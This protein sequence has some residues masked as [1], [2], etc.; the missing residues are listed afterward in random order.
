MVLVGVHEELGVGVVE[1][2]AGGRR[3]GAPSATALLTLRQMRC[4]AH[5][6]A[7]PSRS[8]VDLR[9]VVV[10]PLDRH[11]VHR[12]AHRAGDRDRLGVPRVARPRGSGAG[13]RAHTSRAATFAPHWVSTTPGVIVACSRRLY[14][15]PERLADPA[16]G[17][18]QLRARRDRAIR[19]RARA[20]A[21]RRAGRARAG[22]AGWR[23]RGRRSRRSGAVAARRP[24][25]TAAPLPGV[26]AAGCSRI[27]CP[28]SRRSGP[29]PARTVP[30]VLPS[31]TKIT[32]L[33]GGWSATNST[34][35]LP[36]SAKRS[37]S[38]KSG[39]TTE[40][41]A[42]TTNHGTRSS[43]ESTGAPWLVRGQRCARR[44][45]GRSGARAG[46]AAASGSEPRTEAYLLRKSRLL[47]FVALGA[48]LLPIVVATRPGAA[49]RT[50]SRSA[51]TRSS[52]SGPGTS[53]PR[54]R[55]CSGRGRPRRRA[56]GRTSTT[57]A[58]C[59]STCSRSRSGSSARSTG[60]PIGTAPAEHRRRSSASRSIAYRRGGAV[61]GSAAMLV[62]AVMCWAMGSELLFDPWQPHSLLLPFLFF[63][64]A[65]WALSCGDLVML[66]WAVGVGSLVVA[67]APQLR[68][69]RARARAVGRRRLLPDQPA[70]GRARAVR[71]GAGRAAGELVARRWRSPRSSLVLCWAQPVWEEFTGPGDGNIT[72]LVES[73]STSNARSRSAS[74]AARG[75]VATVLALPPWWLRPSFNDAFVAADGGPHARARA[76]SASP[77]L[78]SLALA[79]GGLLVDRGDLRGVRPRRASAPRYRGAARGRH[80]GDRDHRRPLHRRRTFPR[81]VL[82][83][84]AAPV[85]LAVA[86]RRVHDVRRRSPPTVG[87]GRSQLSSGRR[88][89][90]LVASFVGVT[91]L[92]A[93]L[94]L[95]TYR[96]A[97][98]PD[99]GLVRHPGR[100]RPRPAARRAQRLR[101]R[102][103][104]TS[105]ACSSPSRTAPRSWPSSSGAASRSSSTS[106]VS[107]ASSV[108]TGAT[109]APTRSTG[110]STASARTRSRPAAERDAGR[111]P[112]RA[113]PEGA[114]PDEPAQG[115]RSP[116]RW[117][118]GRLQLTA[119][120]ERRDRRRAGTRC[121]RRALRGDAT[122]GRRVQVPPVHQRV[123]GRRARRQAA[124]D[125]A[126]PALRG[127]PAAGGTTKRSRCSSRRSAS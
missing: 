42:A 95:P 51:T 4:V 19:P 63:L 90:V 25:A 87:A 27:G 79:V 96:G 55:R 66:P 103:S 50:G 67:D 14:V 97:G 108:R 110:S 85:P 126:V 57:R 125:G 121:S 48:A 20:S 88:A 107:C 106:T 92:V 91:A 118:P 58:R 36:Y 39:T 116:T 13:S 47:F 6:I 29:R 93:V 2:L 61:L 114:R 122:A 33:P 37:S 86:A 21:S 44:S 83:R 102:C 53:S 75:C 98:R 70:L 3:R 100:A 124:V 119:F 71:R 89:G 15:A 78:P 68:V 17:P 117:T 72:R 28:G 77:S 65:V 112:S 80:R 49:P 40:K 105:A 69:P 99:R 82:R 32:S 120:G 45:P 26:R 12:D 41:P 94:N 43:L 18:E 59:S 109:T 22:R 23:G 81:T 56:S 113:R 73:L 101:H 111:V 52:P 11:L 30:S 34:R 115:A 10:A 31:S 7:M 9:P 104:T 84:R 127:A 64:M 46:A 5:T 35:A 76:A 38:L 123:R 1:D 60:S 74:T 24:A 62:T 54:T 16:L 8:D